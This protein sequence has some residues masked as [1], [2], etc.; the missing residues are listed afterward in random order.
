MQTPRKPTFLFKTSELCTLAL[1]L[2]TSISHNQHLNIPSIKPRETFPY[3][4]SGRAAFVCEFDGSINPNTVDADVCPRCHPTFVWDRTKPLK[5]IEHIGAHLLFDM[6]IYKTEE[7][8]G[9]CFR[10]LPLCLFYLRRGKN[11]NSMQQIDIKRSQCPN[12]NEKGFSYGPASISSPSS[13]CTNVPVHCPRCPETAPLV[14]K[15]SMRAHYIKHHSSAKF[16]DVANG[17]IASQVERA[18]LSSVWA[19]QHVKKRRQ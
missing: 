10:L 14:W 8:C 9:L 19:N 16:D 1:S 6:A 11:H 5:V 7:Y 3:H 17:F 18:G 4:A 12:L 13:P 2:F 15:Y